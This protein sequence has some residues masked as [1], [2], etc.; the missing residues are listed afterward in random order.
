MTKQASNY[1]SKSHQFS[2]NESGGSIFKIEEENKV[3][4][5]ISNI[6][7]ESLLKE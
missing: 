4:F 5:K 2:S 6:T 3:H 7:R 1:L